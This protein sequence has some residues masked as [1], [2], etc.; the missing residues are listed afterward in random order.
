VSPS[1]RTGR[2]APPDG[3]PT[4]Q[5]GRT[6]RSPP[7]TASSA[8][9]GRHCSSARAHRRPEHGRRVGSRR[10]GDFAVG[11]V[12]SARG[13]P[14]RSSSVQTVPCTSSASVLPP[15]SSLRHDAANS[16][17]TAIDI[18]ATTAGLLVIRTRCQS[19]AARRRVSYQARHATLDVAT[20]TRV[21]TCQTRS[22][23][24]A[25]RGDQKRQTRGTTTMTTV[26]NHSITMRPSFQ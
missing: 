3:D 20:S 21:G 6:G 25:S 9:R 8:P 2:T 22:D 16:A 15:P 24:L 13:S 10:S 23:V 12:R 7:E 5:I 1:V 19:G 14:A 4:V 11:E 26:K 18:I 17:A